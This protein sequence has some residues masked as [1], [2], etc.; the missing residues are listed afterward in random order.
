MRRDSRTTAR[1]EATVHD[2]R[3]CAEKSNNFFLFSKQ[4]SVASFAASWTA[5]ACR[6]RNNDN[7]FVLCLVFL[8]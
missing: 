2:A 4:P 8:R 6:R 3:G 7:D 1:D 5:Q